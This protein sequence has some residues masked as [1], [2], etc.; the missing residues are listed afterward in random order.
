M[1]SNG[2]NCLKIFVLS[3]ARLITLPRLETSFSNL[4]QRAIEA[5]HLM[6]FSLSINGNVASVALN[7]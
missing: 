1:W 6:T 3:K 2:V 4:K 5:K 7:S